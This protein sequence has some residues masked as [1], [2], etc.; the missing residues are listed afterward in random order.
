M[1]KTNA[2]LAGA[3]IGFLLAFFLVECATGASASALPSTD[4]LLGRLCW[5]EVGA[6]D[7]EQCAAVE[8]AL[9]HKAAA[10]GSTFRAHLLAYTRNIT[11]PE[12]TDRR[13]WLAHLGARA[14]EPAGWYPHIPWSAWRGRWRALL[15]FV[16]H[17]RAHPVNPCAGRAWDWGVDGAVERY[18]RAFPRSVVV[19]CGCTPSPG[20]RCNVFLRPF[21]ESSETG[22][23]S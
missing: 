12:R 14:R 1:N 7:F 3:A 11:D 4:V 18:R 17:Q 9:A 16:R 8:R 13:R 10:R 23:A 6:R 2:T 19:D 5:S 15:R 20:R 22:P 21:P